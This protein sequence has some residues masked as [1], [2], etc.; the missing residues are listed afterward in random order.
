MS[1]PH[2]GQSELVSDLEAIFYDDGF[3]A[4]PDR[5]FDAAEYG[6][7]GDDESRCTDAIQDAIDAAA[8]AGGG[9]VT[10]PEGTYRSGALFLKSNVE[11]RLAD[12]AT[13]RAVQDDDAY[14]T[15]ETRV[16]GIEMEWPAALLNV[17][18]EENVR[19]TGGGTIDGNGEYWWEKFNGMRGEYEERGLRWAVDY[20]CERVRPVVV[21]D[22]EDVLLEEFT[23]ERQG[24]WAVTMTYSDRVHVDGVT[25]RGNVG[26]YGP[27]TD[28]INTDSS[29]DVLIENCDVDGNDDCLCVKA[30]R[31]ADGLRVDRP[32]ENV[33]YRDCVTREGGGLV[34]IGSETSGGVR[35]LEVYNIRGEGTNTGIRFKSAKVRGG[36]I[37]NV[38]FHDLEMEGV[39]TVFQWEL[40]WHPDYSYPTIPDDVPEEEYEP[41]WETLTTPVEPPERGI[42]EFRDVTVRNVTAEGTEERAWHANGYPERPIRDVRFEDVTVEAPSAGE[43]RHAENWTMER[44]VARTEDGAGVELADCRNVDRPEIERQ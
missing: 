34:T 44:V 3:A 15:R 43:I 26:G 33:V 22:S 42:P 28:G 14:P 35:N 40:N 9:V 7:A 2:A 23:V 20:D 17:Y 1:T 4:V 37:E 38:R 27:S 39:R 30:G 19:V 36:V 24:F 31:D 6:A 11:L 12:G 18:G 32:A 16:A 5:E 41:H 21:Y 10:L 25:V 29:R 13:L 8:D